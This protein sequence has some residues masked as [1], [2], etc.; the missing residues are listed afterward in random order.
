MKIFDINTSVGH[1][2]FRKLE[3]NSIGEL[4]GKLES[5]EISGA[6]VANVNGLFYMNCHDANIELHEWLKGYADYFTGIATVNPCYAK[7]DKDLRD[8]VQKFK[9][10]GVRLV[11]LY[12]DYTL[13]SASADEAAV[14]AASLDIPVFIPYRIID[15]RQR[16]WMDTE[17]TVGFEQIYDFCMKHPETKI[18]YTESSASADD[19]KGRGKCPNLFIEISRMR[20]SFGQQISKLASAIGNDHLLFGSGSPF[21]EIS[22][23]LLKLAHADLNRNE[24][25]AIAS[26]NALGLFRNEC[27]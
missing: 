7:W 2:P 21:K 10:R 26:G 4:R 23:A 11:P 15:I 6:A 5:H 3:N 18:V 16:H 1:W 13:G 22:P 19:F 27:R 25:K 20:S 9:F 12:H 8:S 24:K 14:L 17:K